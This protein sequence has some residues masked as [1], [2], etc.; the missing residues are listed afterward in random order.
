MKIEAAVPLA[1][2]ATLLLSFTNRHR[3]LAAPAWNITLL[4]ARRWGYAVRFVR[5]DDP[6]VFRASLQL[7]NK[8]M[9]PSWEKIPIMASALNERTSSGAQLYDAVVWLDDDL[10]IN[11]H[12]VPVSSWIS[13]LSQRKKDLLLGAERV[14]FDVALNLS[15]SPPNLGLLIVRNSPWSRS[16][17]EQ[18]LP[19]CTVDERLCS[20]CVWEQDCFDRLYVASMPDCAK[21]CKGKELAAARHTHLTNAANLNCI[22]PIRNY[23]GLCEPWALHFMG[24]TKR[25]LHESALL[26]RARGGQPL[27]QRTLCNQTKMR[28]EVACQGMSTR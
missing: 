7:H 11:Q 28:T 26:W 17:F 27:S 6:D 20:R 3:A 18:F 22:P 16:F 4:Y 13:M 15:W 8:T 19:S 5:G 24:H 21:G 23:W 25:Y 1:E 2:P 14:Q 12:E 9:P 10:F